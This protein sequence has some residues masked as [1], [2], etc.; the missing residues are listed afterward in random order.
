[1]AEFMPK[2]M[3][4]YT[5]DPESTPD[6]MPESKSGSVVDPE[7]VPEAVSWHCCFQLQNLNEPGE[8][9]LLLIDTEGSTTVLECQELLLRRGTLPRIRPQYCSIGMC[10][11]L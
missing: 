5:G 3:S 4:K 8:L 1:M 6:S 10:L 9:P 11:S 7:P 2:S